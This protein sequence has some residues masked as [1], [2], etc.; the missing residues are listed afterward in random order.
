M[1]DGDHS[2]LIARPA[3][4]HNPQSVRCSVPLKLSFGVYHGDTIL[5]LGLVNPCPA[6]KATEP[7]PKLGKPQ[8][9]LELS[10]K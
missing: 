2:C 9:K 6:I 7:K 5:R 1:D 4:P 10:L 8:F 3:G